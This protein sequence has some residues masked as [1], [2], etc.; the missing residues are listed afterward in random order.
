MQKAKFYVDFCMEAG[1]EG[2]CHRYWFTLDLSD[3]EYEEL[4]QMW[5]DQN[6]QLCSWTADEKGH[7]A[8]YEK[9]D[10]AAYY[11]LNEMLKKEQ[12]AHVDPVELYWEI[13][14]ETADA[15]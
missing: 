3:E 7:E 1:G 15:F 9:I 13:S 4:Y 6:C 11:A 12:P 8:L 2:I 10:G 5:Y 14:E